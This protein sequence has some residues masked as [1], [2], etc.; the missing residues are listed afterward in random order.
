MLIILAFEIANTFAKYTAEA[1]AIVSATAGAWIIKINNENLSDPNSI[2]QFNINSLTYSSN[3]YV[4]QNKIAPT[5]SGYFDIE[6]DPAG[7]S[8]AVRFDVTINLAALNISDSIDFQNATMVKNNQQPE[9]LIRTG[10]NTYTGIISLAEVKS[11]IKPVARFY[12]QWEDDLTGSHDAA[13]SV[14]GVQRTVSN[15]V[16]PVSVALSQYTGETIVQYV[17]E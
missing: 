5:S 14:L 3:Q 7:T 6:F 11:G 13:D 12:I 1:N 15:L 2:R 4:L 17:G 9:A 16:L 10:E 8:V